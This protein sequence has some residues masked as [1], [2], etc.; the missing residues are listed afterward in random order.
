MAAVAPETKNNSSLKSK[1]M[2]TKKTIYHLIVDKSGSMSDCIDRTIEGFNEQLKSVRLL[3]D[4]YPEQDITLG[5]TMFNERVQPL[6]YETAP[7]VVRPLTVKSYWTEGSTA[8]LDAIGETVTYLQQAQV[9]SE[10]SV[11]TTIVVVILTD[12]YE[13]ASSRYRLPD[14]RSMIAGLEETGKW[15][16]S[17]IGA[18][19][20]AVDVAE[21]MAIKRHN[22]FQFDK[23]EM[24]SQVWDRLSNAVYSYI[25]KKERGEDLGDFI[26]K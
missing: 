2:K 6:F 5:L 18:T 7:D 4:R 10:Q 1:K 20:D 22:S 9:R 16:F 21:Q 24:K 15:T 19:L 8:L 14:I 12:G 25:D 26:E 13:N 17:F 23:S 3:A 11:P